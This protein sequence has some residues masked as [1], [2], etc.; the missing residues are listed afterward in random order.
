MPEE[1]V[2]TFGQD[3]YLERAAQPVELSPIFVLLA[4]QEASYITG[5]VYGA[6]GGRPI[7]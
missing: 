3:S 5:M 1:K 6:T 7:G 2:K 4:S